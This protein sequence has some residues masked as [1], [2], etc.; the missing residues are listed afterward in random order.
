M[1]E[2]IN[3]SDYISLADAANHAPY[4]QEYLSLRARQGKL[5][6]VKRGRTWFTTLGWL[7]DYLHQVDQ[8]KTELKTVS[9][10]TAASLGTDEVS[11][12]ADFSF[13]PSQL[14]AAADITDTEPIGSVAEI[15]H[16]YEMHSQ[17][18]WDD[19]Q[20]T[21]HHSSPALDKLFEKLDGATQA[22]PKNVTAYSPIALDLDEEDAVVDSFY[23]QGQVAAP[24]AAYTSKS[25]S[26]QPYVQSQPTA[27]RMHQ[28]KVMDDDIEAEVEGSW[29]GQL[30]NMLQPAMAVA[31]IVLVMGLGM[32][33]DGPLKLRQTVA[34]GFGTMMQQVGDNMIALGEANDAALGKAKVSLLSAPVISNAD[35]TSVERAVAAAPTSVQSVQNDQIKTPAA[36]D[37]Q[38]SVNQGVV[39]G[40]SDLNQEPGFWGTILLGLRTVFGR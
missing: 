11:P 32:I 13:H 5:R 7:D 22:E 24:V 38:S 3:K 18:S 33:L 34:I 30:G 31:A 37:E 29:I 26:H 17:F 4:S 27:A 20:S 21:A 36:I 16:A 15:D 35:N 8:A 9:V 14:K 40:T 6:A 23:D 19:D 10:V 25:Q 2:L 28:K 1:A 39:A 12:D